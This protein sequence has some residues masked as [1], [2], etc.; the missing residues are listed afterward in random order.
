MKRAI[1]LL[2]VR[3]QPI[4]PLMYVKNSKVSHWRCGCRFGNACRTPHDA[5]CRKAAEAARPVDAGAE[6]AVLPVLRA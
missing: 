3:D 4:F 2:M 1:S 6:I 5:P